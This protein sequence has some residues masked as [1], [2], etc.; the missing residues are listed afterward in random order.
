[1]QQ[2]AVEERLTRLYAAYHATPD[3]QLER[4]QRG[5]QARNLVAWYDAHLRRSPY[6]WDD[7][8]K[9][10][11]AFQALRAFSEGAGQGPPA[12]TLIDLGCGSG[13][14]LAVIEEL[15]QNKERTAKLKLFGVDFA[16]EGIK[17]AK[18]RT[19]KVQYV[20]ADLMT[21]EF[22]KC[23]DYVLSLGVFEHLENPVAAFRTMRDLLLPDGLAYVEIPVYNDDEEGFG[24]HVEGRQLSW[25][26]RKG[27]YE[28]IIS[29]AGLVILKDLGPIHVGVHPALQEH[30]AYLLAK[31]GSPYQR[32]GRFFS[33]PWTKFYFRYFFSHR[34]YVV[35]WFAPEIMKS[36][37]RR[38]LRRR[39]D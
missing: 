7:H 35:P 28:E 3:P 31:P 26:L 5:S 19:K 39:G 21:L 33:W 37:G 8:G 25:K 17:V 29:G 6:R 12:G 18:Q 30:V 32:K 2:T 13:Y 16:L 11:F 38:L 9:P 14:T 27:T 23:F 24:R 1:M 20:V 36:A 22:K 4:Y 10:G 34:R 15:L